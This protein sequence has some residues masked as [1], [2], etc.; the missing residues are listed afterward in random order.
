MEKIEIT[1][2]SRAKM[3]GAAFQERMKA[4]SGLGA[5]PQGQGGGRRSGGG[6]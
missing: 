1:T 4:N 2:I 3:E 5:S 6:R